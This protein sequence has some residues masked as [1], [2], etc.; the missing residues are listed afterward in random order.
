MYLQMHS[1]KMYH[2]LGIL[3]WT[4]DIHNVVANME[5]QFGKTQITL[6]KAKAGDP[7]CLLS[8]GPLILGSKSMISRNGALSCMLYPQTDVTPLTMLIRHGLLGEFA[9]H[10]DLTCP[11]C[12]RLC[13]NSAPPYTPDSSHSVFWSEGA[14]LLW[15]GASRCHLLPISVLST[16]LCFLNKALNFLF[17]FCLVALIPLLPVLV[18]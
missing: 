5:A 1:G 4:L 16:K 12:A 3:M 7:A 15:D 10:W 14:I 8:R 2:L 17:F 18:L 11:C 6:G 13:K 9:S